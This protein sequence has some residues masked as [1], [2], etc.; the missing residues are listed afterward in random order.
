MTR[1]TMNTAASVDNCR[2]QQ[3]CRVLCA[4][5]AKR[6]GV[7]AI[8]KEPDQLGKKQMVQAPLKLPSGLCLHRA[9]SPQRKNEA[10]VPDTLNLG[11]WAPLSQ[12]FPARKAF[13]SKLHFRLGRQTCLH[14]KKRYYGQVADMITLHFS[15]L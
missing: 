7:H 12:V 13:T 11:F 2:R 9:P 4:G 3:S 14:G 10:F 15:R 5:F 1:N 6:G 8:A